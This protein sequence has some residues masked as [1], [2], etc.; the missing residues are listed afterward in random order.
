M[1]TE[2]YTIYEYDSSTNKYLRLSDI[3][4]KD[5][6]SAKNAYAKKHGWKKSENKFLFAKIPVC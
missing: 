4:A 6:A 3:S 5:S 1:K 2:C